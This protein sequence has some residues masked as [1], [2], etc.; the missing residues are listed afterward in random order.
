MVSL[1]QL[2]TKSHPRMTEALSELLC[3]HTHARAHT[4]IHRHNHAHTHTSITTQWKGL[5]VP[6]RAMLHVGR[7]QT[8]QLQLPDCLAQHT[9]EGNSPPS[10][11]RGHWKE[12]TEKEVCLVV[13]VKSLIKCLVV[14]VKSQIQRL[15][16]T[17]KS[18]KKGVLW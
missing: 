17:V 16:V 15:V 9:A 2:D 5:L 6:C 11:S 7:G 10:W 12:P 1:T 18:H 13:I 4:H 8:Q 14:A 3:A